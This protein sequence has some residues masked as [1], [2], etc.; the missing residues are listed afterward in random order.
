VGGESGVARE[1]QPEYWLPRFIAVGP[2][3]TGTTWLHAV[4]SGHINLPRYHKETRFFDVNYEKGLDW[5]ARNFDPALAS[6][7]AGEIC[8]TYFH[9]QPA[10][11]R[12]AQLVPGVRIICSLRDP[13]ERV[14]SLYKTKR[15]HGSSAP[16]FEAALQTDPELMESGR[17]CFHLMRWR[18]KFGS[19]RVLTLVY[20]D[21]VRDPQSYLDTICAFVGIARILLTANQHRRVNSSANLTS[22]KNPGWTRMGAAAAEWLKTRGWGTW[23]AAAKQSAP[24]R[25][26]MGGGGKIQPPDVESAARLRRLFRPEVERLEEIL[27]RDLSVWK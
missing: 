12:I 2:P 14:F 8:P 15:A 6:L 9:S 16:S 22:P 23:V 17:Y 20:E 7:P 24:G 26:F 27:E 13:V 10:Q 18:S 11:S 19:D 25:L 5:Y 1:E 4:V 21:L 3:R